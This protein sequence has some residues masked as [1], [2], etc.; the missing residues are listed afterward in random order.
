MAE[1]ITP[2]LVNVRIKTRREVR[3]SSGANRCIAPFVANAFSMPR[4]QRV[5]YI[6]KPPRILMCVWLI[7]YKTIKIQPYTFLN[8]I[9][10]YPP[11][12]GGVVEAVSVVVEG[13]VAGP[14]FGGEA[15]EV[16]A[17]SGAARR[18]QVAE[19]IVL[20]ACAQGF[21]G[22]HQVGN[23]PVAIG[24]VVVMRTPCAGGRGVAM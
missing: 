3:R 19:G 24:M 20:V 9:P 1:C 21:N 7:S 17:R 22:A 10:I 16:G 6:D 12:Q 8:W 15:V 2:I 5:S 14:Q 13:G 4:G 11:L 23:I 18:D